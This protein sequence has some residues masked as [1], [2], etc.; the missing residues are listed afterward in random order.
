LKKPE[1][2]ITY[3]VVQTGGTNFDNKKLGE[4][5]SI[6]KSILPLE[7]RSVRTKIMK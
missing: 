5:V 3:N 6:E 7:R 2:T 1:Q 4:K